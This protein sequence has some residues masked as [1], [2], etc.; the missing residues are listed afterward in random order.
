MPST[1]FAVETAPIAQ[2]IRFLAEACDTHG[3]QI[4]IID[5]YS[6][7]LARV[8]N[9]QSWFLVGAGAVSSYP[10][11]NAVAAG[12]AKDKAHT[13]ALL[14]RAGFR[15]PDGEHFFLIAAYRDQRGPGREIADA[16]YYAKQLGFPV[17]V[18]PNDGARGDFAE[19]IHDEHALL[20]HLMAMAPRY[21]CALVQRVVSGPEYRVFVVD[22][23]VMFHY[24]KTGAALIGDGVHTV[25]KLLDDANAALRAR[26]ISPVPAESPILQAA[27]AAAKLGLLSIPDKGQRLLFTQRANL[28]GGGD[29]A[30][31]SVTASPAL[32]LWAK[33]LAET[34]DLRVCG[35]DVIAPDGIDHPDTAIV[36]EVNSNPSLAGAHAAGYGA[37]VQEIWRRVGF[38]ALAEHKA[39]L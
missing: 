35:I 2:H 18:K 37:V 36:M 11:N 28:S 30:D 34:A 33:K 15:V 21:H 8:S 32:A 3:W 17:F 19:L 1:V 20:F 16:L 39:R 24:R 27:L 6:G 25:Q 12:V 38:A 10:I 22:G 9:G 14:S 23:T 4:E 13:A 26:R 5:R 29:L 7:H 31:F